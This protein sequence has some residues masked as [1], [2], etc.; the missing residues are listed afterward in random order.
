MT[1]RGSSAA[2]GRAGEEAAACALRKEGMKVLF[3]NVRSQAGEIDL[4]AQDGE[5]LVFVEVKHWPAYGLD[6]LDYGINPKKKRRIIETAKYFLSM[7][8]EYNGRP[9]RFDVV[10]V[11]AGDA[12]YTRFESA[13]ME[14]EIET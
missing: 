6:S 14:T 7:H 10:F 2:I 4:I 8:R 3:R 1:G 12:S 5:S 11:S 9:V 13:F